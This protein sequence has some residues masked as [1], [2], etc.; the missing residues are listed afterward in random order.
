MNRPK[1]SPILSVSS[2]CL[3]K[4][5]AIS[6]LVHDALPVSFWLLFMNCSWISQSYR[7]A[8]E[9]FV[10]MYCLSAS[11][12]NPDSFELVY[13][14]LQLISGC[15]FSDARSSRVSHA[16]QLLMLYSVDY[17]RRTLSGVEITPAA[18]ERSH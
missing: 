18:Q 5:D 8:I 14:W 11:K 4:G 15:D 16:F 6:G 7:D 9:S 12:A 1:T 13:I 10:G 3:R 17:R 2:R